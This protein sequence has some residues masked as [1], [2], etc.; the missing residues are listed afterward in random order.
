LLERAG[1]KVGPTIELHPFSREHAALWVD[2]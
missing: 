1:L 2:V